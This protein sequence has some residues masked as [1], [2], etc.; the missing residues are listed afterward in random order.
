MTSYRRTASLKTVVWC[1]AL[2]CVGYLS[3]NTVYGSQSWPPTVS[4]YL[5]QAGPDASEANVRPS[6]KPEAQTSQ[7]HETQQGQAA[8]RGERES[9]QSASQ[10]QPT[11][12]NQAAKVPVGA[13]APQ[14]AAAAEQGRGA[15]AETE[16]PTKPVGQA[17]ASD[18]DRPPSVAQIFADQP[19]VLT[20]K[21][22][23]VLEPSLSYAYATNNQVSLLGF[24]I[25][26]AIVIGLIDIQSVNRNIWVAALDARYG[27]TNRFELEA[28]IPYVYQSNSTI[29]RPV[30]TPADT[31][32][33]FNATGQGLGDIELAARYQLNKGGPDSSYWIGTFRVKTTTGTS[34]FEVPLDPV[35]HL[36]TELATGSGFW[37]IQPQLTWIFPTDPAVIFGNISYLYNFSRDVGNGFGT[38]NPGNALGIN[39]GLGLALNDKLSFSVGFQN[40]SVFPPTQS[41]NVTT[42]LPATSTVQVGTLSIGASYQLNAKTLINLSVGV[43]V[44]QAAPG[45]QLTLRIP[46]TL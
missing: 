1:S 32:K 46:Y 7:T 24:T 12:E 29:A 26:P 4:E 22:K 16:T 36:P 5:K 6:K 3:I 21:G 28:K 33:V 17:P 41:G 20:P 45:M 34:P 19:G 31:E 37:A 27:V 35:N 43:G 23:M 44:T 13:Q 11:P 30:A 39:F 14:S 25:L 2:T 38:V 9:T 15:E 42:Q 18:S 8:G 10:Q 40:F